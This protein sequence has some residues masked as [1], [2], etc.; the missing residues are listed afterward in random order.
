MGIRHRRGV[1]KLMRSLWGVK[2]FERRAR[3]FPCDRPT[4]SL[5]PKPGN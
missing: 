3:F 5:Q 2:P 1:W 4:W